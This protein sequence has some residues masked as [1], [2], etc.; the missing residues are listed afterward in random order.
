MMVFRPAQI[1]DTCVFRTCCLFLKP[2]ATGIA[3]RYHFAVNDSMCLW[4]LFPEKFVL[5]SVTLLL[6]ACPLAFAQIFPEHHEQTGPNLR[7]TPL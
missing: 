4:E 6:L 3:L 5:S 7:L 2:L 1:L